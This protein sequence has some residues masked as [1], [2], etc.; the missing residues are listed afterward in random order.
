M[1]LTALVIGS[2]NPERRERERTSLEISLAARLCSL[3]IC[4]ILG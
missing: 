4:H 1:S 2:F 3:C